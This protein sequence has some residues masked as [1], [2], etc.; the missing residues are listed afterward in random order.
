MREQGGAVKEEDLDSDSR[1][2]I[3]S[4]HPVIAGLLLFPHIFQPP[5]EVNQSH[6]SCRSLRGDE[7]T[8]DEGKSERDGGRGTGRRER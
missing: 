5:P 3:N 8:G 4:P 1:G 2:N 6:S 7:V